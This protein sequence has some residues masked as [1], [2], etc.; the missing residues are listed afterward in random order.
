MTLVFYC[1]LF[2]YSHIWPQIF[3][4]QWPSPLSTFFVT[5]RIISNIPMIFSSFTCTCTL[6]RIYPWLILNNP[7]LLM[8]IV[9]WFGF[10]TP[11]QLLPMT[12]YLVFC[13]RH[14]SSTIKSSSD[15]WKFALHLNFT[16]DRPLNNPQL[17][18]SFAVYCQLI[19][20]AEPIS[21]VLSHQLGPWSSVV[22][23]DFLIS[24]LPLIFE[25]L[26]CSCFPQLRDPLSILDHLGL[27]LLIVDL[28]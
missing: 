19:C 7:G 18:W 5:G 8:L 14:S 12:Q 1:W 9:D 11:Y 27:L 6:K 17:P 21:V 22:V 13:C 4:S 23:T 20:V 2:I 25:N 26:P 16:F 10:L 28:F 3:C 15:F 24:N